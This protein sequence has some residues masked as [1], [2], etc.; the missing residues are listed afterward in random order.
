MASSATG[1][2]NTKSFSEL[3]NYGSVPKESSITYQGIINSNF[4]LSANKMCDDILELDINF[5]DWVNPI[6]DIKEKLCSLLV[7]TKFDG[8]GFRKP[9]D[10]VFVLDKSGSMTSKLSRDVN[11]KESCIDLAKQAFIELLNHLNDDDRISLI[12]IDDNAKNILSLT[13]KKQI[14]DGKMNEYE[15]LD[16]LYEAIK[17]I[18]AYNGTDLCEG[19]RAS[20]LQF[21]KDFNENREKRIIYTTDMKDIKD[22]E[23]EEYI[24][25]S[26]LKGIY[27]TI[28]A[29][30]IELNSNFVEKVTHN[31]GCNYLSAIKAEDF[32]KIIIEDFKYNFFPI[33]HD[34]QIKI[35]SSDF[36]LIESLGTDYSLE[37]SNDDSDFNYW[38]SI[39]HIYEKRN[40]RNVAEI[41]LFCLKKTNKTKSRIPKN[42]ISNIFNFL[43]TKEI[44]SCRIHSFF[45]SEKILNNDNH[46]SLSLIRGGL[47]LLRL[48]NNFG[49]NNSPLNS[50]I[51][52]KLEYLGSDLNPYSKEYKFQFE[53][54][55]YKNQNEV[56]YIKT[57]LNYNFTET[58]LKEFCNH[59]EKQ[60]I[61][62]NLSKKGVVIYCYVSFVKMILG[63][64]G[65][66]Q[67]GDKNLIIPD[68][69]DGLKS[70]LKMLDDEKNSKDY[71]NDLDRLFKALSNNKK[72]L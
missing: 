72:Y 40:F 52:I 64:S 35:A 45:S 22:R 12:A 58:A 10:I 25:N 38:R 33:A 63:I 3:L 51:K 29:I 18:K 50:S 2:L 46:K 62:F 44:E 31:R 69:F 26:A 24:K 37:K 1:S 4:F 14:F 67:D 57:H 34:I 53:N 16:K 30:G 49:I 6:Y 70:L 32:R 36:E 43:K 41:I 68:S 61:E 20:L 48:K 42:V 19:F 55:F 54:S 11:S 71:C 47:I 8:I 7:K 9:I 21:D 15:S 39:N 65:K 17:S 13:S 56:D 60:G 27:T 28:L 66:I 23:F 59:C 5:I